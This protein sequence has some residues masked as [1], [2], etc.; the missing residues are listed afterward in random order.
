MHYKKPEYHNKE[1]DSIYQGKTH[2]TKKNLRRQNFAGPDILLTKGHMIPKG[3]CHNRERHN[4]DTFYK[5]HALRYL[6]I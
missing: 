6:F 1:T 3:R 5:W 2:E 4:R